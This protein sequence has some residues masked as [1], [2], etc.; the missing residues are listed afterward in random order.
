MSATETIRN[1][2]IAESAMRGGP[3]GPVPMGTGLIRPS[4]KRG[5][6]SSSSL[7]HAY[8]VQVSTSEVSMD[9]LDKTREWKAIVRDEIEYK[10][11]G[12]VLPGL[13]GVQS[14]KFEAKN[15]E[16]D[17]YE[18]SM[19]HCPECLLWTITKVG[20]DEHL[21]SKAHVQLL[22]SIDTSAFGNMRWIDI[23]WDQDNDRILSEVSKH[24]GVV[25]LSSEL[26]KYGVTIDADKMLYLS[27]NARRTSLLDFFAAPA[28]DDGSRA[29]PLESLTK[30][31][32]VLT[33]IKSAVV[34][35]DTPFV[36]FPFNEAS[37]E[38]QA[39][40]NAPPEWYDSVCN[41]F[42]KKMLADI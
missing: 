6:A 17:T 8:A 38:R 26:I 11:Q 39:F 9:D 24:V 28:Q 4:G 15:D 1:N 27:H 35:D 12:Q 22:S 13:R 37:V 10:T 30:L 29:L 2:I 34:A 5:R 23:K 41:A 3:V 14:V 16:N 42:T 33:M 40:A 18:I 31:I 32:D 19:V 25:T 21:E 20:D 36:P 7:P